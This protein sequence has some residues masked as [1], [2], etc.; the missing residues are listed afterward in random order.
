M[1]EADDQIIEEARLAL[2]GRILRCPLGENPNDCPLHD[3]RL[4]PIEERLAWLEARP[5][6]EVVELYIQ[7]VMCM[8]RKLTEQADPG[9]TS[10]YRQET[11]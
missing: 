10:A 5:D 4:K 3:L 8:K 11:L 2:H 7:H 1:T 6:P 9:I